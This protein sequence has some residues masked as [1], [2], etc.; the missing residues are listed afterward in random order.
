MTIERHEPAESIKVVPLVF[1]EG[2]EPAALEEPTEV[3]WSEEPKSAVLGVV[4]LALGVL[5]GVTTGIGVGV[6]SAGGFAAATV[7]A[8]V[9]VG[10]SILA[11]AAGIAAIVLKRG[12]AEA[13][14]GVVLGVVGNPLVLLVVLQFVGGT[15]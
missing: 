1:G 6:A 11:V 7:L 15:S 3:E 10:L 13:T 8:Y 5:S 14:V 4:A 9:A 12:R 2:K